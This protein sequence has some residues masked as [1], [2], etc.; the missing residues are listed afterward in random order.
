LEIRLHQLPP[1]KTAVVTKILTE[2]WL[3]CCLKN[4][5]L[6]PGTV[7]SCRYRSPGGQVTALAFRGTVLALRT[8]QLRKI[9][10]RL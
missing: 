5:G 6:I 7:V 3:A 2:P 1:G 4:Y 9:R 8:S 10:V